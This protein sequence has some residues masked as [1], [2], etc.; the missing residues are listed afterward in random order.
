MSEAFYELTDFVGK[1]TMELGNFSSEENAIR[2]LN[3]LIL[4]PRSA[5]LVKRTVAG[6]VK[7]K[8]LNQ[9]KKQ[10]KQGC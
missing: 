2:V 5:F 1:P 4:P 6:T 9:T 7:L 3:K 10:E 8:S